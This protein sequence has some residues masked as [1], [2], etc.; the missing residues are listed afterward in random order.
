ML[1]SNCPMCNIKKLK[2]PKEKEARE[3]LSNLLGVKVPILSDIPI[4]NT[5]F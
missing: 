3:L 2:F 1:L 4:V 5:I